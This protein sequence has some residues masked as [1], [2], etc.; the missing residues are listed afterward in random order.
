MFANPYLGT[1]FEKNRTNQTADRDHRGYYNQKAFVTQRS[2]TEEY[3]LDAIIK[4]VRSGSREMALKQALY[5]EL[6]H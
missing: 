6:G 1:I 3:E 4:P 2:S 5:G